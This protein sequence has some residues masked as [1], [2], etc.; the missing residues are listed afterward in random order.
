MFV[1]GGSRI[2]VVKIQSPFPFLSFLILVKRLAYTFYYSL[3]IAKF[4][5]FSFRK[6][7]FQRNR[8]SIFFQNYLSKPIFCWGMAR[9]GDP[10]I[11]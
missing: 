3:L 4:V 8:Q 10:R 5:F 9:D 2:T 6:K 11:A 7:L 1:N